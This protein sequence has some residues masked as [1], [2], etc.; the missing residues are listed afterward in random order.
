MS[1][2]WAHGASA[3]SWSDS[4]KG[5]SAAGTHIIP[6]CRQAKL[7]SVLSNICTSICMSLCMY[8]TPP[9]W[10]CPMDGKGRQAKW[11]SICDEMRVPHL[12]CHINSSTEMGHRKPT[13]TREV[14]ADYSFTCLLRFMSVGYCC[15]CHGQKL[16]LETLGWYPRL[17]SKFWFWDPLVCLHF[18]N[19]LTK[20]AKIAKLS[21]LENLS[22]LHR[23]K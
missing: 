21:V 5:G 23:S 14:A 11:M 17:A 16:E 22:F 3:P 6:W 20:N 12:S 18:V 4:R 2:R 13:T 15:C 10:C 9:L 8:V 7:I 19:K 1:R